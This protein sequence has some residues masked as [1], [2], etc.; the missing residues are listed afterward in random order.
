[1]G[2][3]EVRTRLS[4]PEGQVW[5]PDQYHPSK[6]SELSL[7]VLQVLQD[8]N[9]CGPGTTAIFAQ[10]STVA[11]DDR[12]ILVQQ[13][14]TDA[15]WRELARYFKKYGKLQESRDQPTTELLHVATTISDPR[16]RIVFSRAINPAFAIAEVISMLAGSDDLSFLA[17]WNPRMK[18][19]SDD[20]LTLCGAYGPRIGSQ[21]SLDPELASK[22]R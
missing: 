14:D 2:I 7:R 8:Q 16:Q 9:G 4:L 10:R 20:G 13:K 11:G 18:K 19:F 1:P 5:K 21:P 12:L 6:Y 22:L 3:P 17:F 15:A